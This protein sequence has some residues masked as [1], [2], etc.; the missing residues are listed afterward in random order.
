M[1]VIDQKM[2]GCFRYS[3]IEVPLHIAPV[4][5]IREPNLK[6][7]MDLPLTITAE[8]TEMYEKCFAEQN[9]DLLSRIHNASGMSNSNWTFTTA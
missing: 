5:S 3:R 2:Y 8:E 4:P 6:C 9:L 7:L 1:S